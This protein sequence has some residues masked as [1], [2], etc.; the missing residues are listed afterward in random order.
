MDFEQFKQVIP[1]A[2]YIDNL[3][4]TI[5]K[6]EAIAGEDTIEFYQTLRNLRNNEGPQF[7]EIWVAGMER[8]RVEML[9]A[10]KAVH[11]TALEDFK[12]IKL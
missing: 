8:L 10:L 2:R 12:K 11:A 7:Y 5:S 3:E 9:E 6:V 1:A 4:I